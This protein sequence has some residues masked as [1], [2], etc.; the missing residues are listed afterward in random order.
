M[1]PKI[2]RIQGHL[3]KKFAGNYTMFTDMSPPPQAGP[4]LAGGGRRV[5]RGAVQARAGAGAARAPARAA[6]PAARLV[7]VTPHSFIY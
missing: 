7:P 1:T 6:R 5:G 3:F 4:A 2:R